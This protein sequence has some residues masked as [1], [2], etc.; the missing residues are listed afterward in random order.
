MKKLTLS[1]AAILAVSGW[2][3]SHEA[4]AQSDVLK[5][6]GCL[7]CHDAEKKKVGPSLKD[8]A[9]KKPNADAVV[10]QMKE[11][12]KG[13]HP[14]VAGSDADLKAAVEAAAATK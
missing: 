8:I 10:A 4:S 6:K 5:S 1:I 3:L 9:A 14:K 7:N 13:G 12:K 2:V 11:G